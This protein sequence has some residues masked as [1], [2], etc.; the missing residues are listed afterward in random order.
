MRQLGLVSAT[1]LVVANMIG[2]G[3][4]T[5]TGFLLAD[6]G[7]PSLVILAWMVGAVLALSGALCYGAMA[8]AIPESGGEYAY[9]SKTI[10]PAAGF[11]AGWVS[12]LAGFSA[13]LAAVA[14]GF[15]EYT[16]IWL[17]G[18]DS[19]LTGSSLLFVCAAIHLRSAVVGARIQ[20]GVVLLKVVALVGFVVFGMMQ[21]PGVGEGIPAQEDSIV[22]S[23]GFPWSAFA[24]SLVWISFSYA[25]WN[26]A[27]YIGSEVADPERNLPRSLVIGTLVVAFLYV[28]ANAVFVYSGPQELLAG[29]LEVAQIAAKEIGGRF[30]EQAVTAVI[31]IALTTSASAMM[32]A[33]PRV[34]H[35]MAL[36]GLLPSVC[37]DSELRP[38]AQVPTRAIFLQW[39]VAMAFLWTGAFEQLLTYIGFT[40]SVSNLAVVIGLILYFKRHGLPLNI[41]GGW[42]APIAFVSFTLFAIGFGFKRQPWECS[43]GAGTLVL[44]LVIYVTLIAPRPQAR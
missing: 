17:S 36:D 13:P 21:W 2:A 20:N 3:V 26:A 44:G 19:R 25:G 14:I 7:S 32:M 18:W 40:L 30:W 33:G 23:T 24:I 6:L 5:T 15:G 1:A 43:L 38:G 31:A 4:F 29:K 41:L 10:H 34:Y 22:S 35:R 39:A 9:L 42:L 12:L 11:L 16:K 28:G 27:A 37:R 8:R